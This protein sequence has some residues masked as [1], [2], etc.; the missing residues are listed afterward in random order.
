MWLIFYIDCQKKWIC[1]CNSYCYVMLIWRKD[2]YVCASVYDMIETK[3]WH[4]VDI[5]E[6]DVFCLGVHNVSMIQL[7]CD[8][9][10]TQKH[11]CRW[12]CLRQVTDLH[13]TCVTR[14]KYR[15]SCRHDVALV[16]LWCQSCWPDTDTC[17]CIEL[18]R[19]LDPVMIGSS[20]VWQKN[21]HQRPDSVA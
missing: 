13:D 20:S 15:L 1:S 4:D 7:W 8:I 10:R 5:D 11:M 19:I 6:R 18:Y 17:W 14:R 16:C 3:I 12:N 9:E 2:K 21:G